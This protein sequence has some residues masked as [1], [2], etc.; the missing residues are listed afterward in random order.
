MLTHKI[1]NRNRINKLQKQITSFKLNKKYLIL[2]LIN[3]KNKFHKTIFK[4][5]T[6][7]LEFKLKMNHQLSTKKIQNYKKEL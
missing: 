3:N 2:S 4:N 1:L 5:K 7:N 6:N